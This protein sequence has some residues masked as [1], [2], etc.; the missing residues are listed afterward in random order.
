M[1]QKTISLAAFMVLACVAFSQQ[2]D[3]G[4]VKLR[5]TRLTYPLVN[6]WIAEFSKEYPNIKVS[7]APAA[8]ADSIDFS[9][10]SYAL[11]PKELEGN[12]EGVVVTRYV[13][14][15]VANSQRPGLAELQ[16]KGITDKNLSD[17]FFTSEKPTFIASAQ[18]ETPITLYVRDRPV[19]AV[20]A[21]A[22]HFGNDPKALKGTGIKGDDQDLAEAVRKDINGLSFN[23][24]GFIYD[25]KTRKITDGLA[26][27]PLDL[28]E[29]G[30]IDQDEQIY[31]TVD[32]VINFIEE[33]HHSKFVNERVNFVFNKS[34]KN[35]SAGIFLNW[36][37]TKG[38]KFN[39]E[40]GF[41]YQDSEFLT[42]QRTLAAATFS[43]AS[44]EGTSDLMKNRKSK[45]VNK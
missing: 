13:Q 41:L 18:P 19:C 38:Q 21:F 40:L 34:S 45:Q 27:I 20:K 23:N 30:K 31:N 37:L 16:A 43:S 29:N 11:T 2:K 24:L 39:H 25:I 1:K 4:I 42:E 35:T 15:P 3:A 33:T 44:C 7:I 10:A 5:G 17:L 6:K 9:I 22:T 26:V 36:V 12:K 32:D 28:N 8:P 14:L